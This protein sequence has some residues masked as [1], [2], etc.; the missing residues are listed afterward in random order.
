MHSR[1]VF[2]ARS[3]HLRTAFVRRPEEA[4][5]LPWIERLPGEKRI[6]N[7][8]GQTFVMQHYFGFN[9][10]R[11]HICHNEVVAES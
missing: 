2:L 1:T 6:K 11:A 8:H 3:A 7:V 9:L 10:I 5:C 4:L